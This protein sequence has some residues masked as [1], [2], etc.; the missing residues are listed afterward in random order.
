MTID[1]KNIAKLYSLPLEVQFCKKCVVSNQRPR[2]TFDEHGVC[3]ACRFAEY[4]KSKIDWIARANELK[5]LCDKH[6]SS[7]GSYDVIVPGSGGKDSNYVAH[8]LRNVYGMHPLTVTWAP[9]I[10]TDIGKKNLTAFIDSGFDNILI[11]PNGAIHRLLTKAA[12]I[13]MGDP[14]QP[15]IFGQYSAPFRVALQYNIQ[16]V[17]YGEDGEVEYGGAM[18]KADRPS[19]SY[20]DFVMNRFSGT[21]PKS[22]SNY[23]IPEIELRKYGLSSD[24]LSEIKSK[25]IIQHFFSYYHKWVPQDNFYYSVEHTGFEPN[26]ERN[27]GTYSKYAS[28]DDR[29]DGFHFYLAYIKFG[30]GRCLSDAA[31]EIRDGHIDRDEAIALVKKYDGEFPKKYYND[32]LEYCGI[33]ESTFHQVIESWRSD[34]LWEKNNGVWNLKN[35]VW[36]IYK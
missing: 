34:H 21:F 25:G 23:G 30:H 31:H 5:T 33:S 20:D 12:F 10:Y 1:K 28:L 15:F 6:R 19:L 22:F 11:T 7:D 26:P 13:E 18:D 9:H 17:F 29:L 36:K 27:E 24:E 14:F 8:M 16:L 2:I 4:K 3:S 32:F 35:P